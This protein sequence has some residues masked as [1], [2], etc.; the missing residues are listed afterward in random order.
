MADRNHP[1]PVEMKVLQGTFRKD[2]APENPVKLESLL[3]APP[4][5]ALLKTTKPKIESEQDYAKEKERLNK[6]IWK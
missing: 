1:K 6:M 4:M 3:K 2:R 5:P